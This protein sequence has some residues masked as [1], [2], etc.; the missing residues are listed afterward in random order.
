MSVGLTRATSAGFFDKTNAAIQAGET[1]SIAY[2][3]SLI[4]I[5]FWQVEDL[6]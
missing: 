3:N 6:H 1:M 4:V 5:H 2:L